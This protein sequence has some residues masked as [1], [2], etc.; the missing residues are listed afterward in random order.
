M[1]N[2]EYSSFYYRGIM[3][4]T[5]AYEDGHRFGVDVFYKDHEYHQDGFQTKHHAVKHGVEYIDNLLV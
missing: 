2:S 5:Y 1:N 3:I 4:R